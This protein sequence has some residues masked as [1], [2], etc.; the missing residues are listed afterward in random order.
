MPDF[1]KL[2]TPLPPR[3]FW[4]LLFFLCLF[5]FTAW[6]LRINAG[7]EIAGVLSLTVSVIALIASPSDSRPAVWGALA[8]AFVLVVL[9]ALGYLLYDSFRSIDVKAN[10][11]FDGA[12]QNLPVLM[13]G[14]RATFTIQVPEPRD[15]L[16]ISFR[17]TDAPDSERF[18]D[19]GTD[20]TTSVELLLDGSSE[21]IRFK[22]DE[23]RTLPVRGNPDI[24]G[25]LT[26]NALVDCRM[27]V[28]V[29]RA[30]LHN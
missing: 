1:S 14:Q 5:G 6:L 30:E 15:H 13:N 25:A 18:Q 24:G 7:A 16:T 20:S 2:K 11:R 21:E 27:Q 9:G 28:Q 3:F 10:V 22:S 26:M 8:S 29:T 12:Q 4:T 17:I 23:E 19:C